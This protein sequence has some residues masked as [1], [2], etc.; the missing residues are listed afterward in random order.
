MILN[1]CSHRTMAMEVYWCIH[2]SNTR[3]D[4]ELLIRQHYCRSRRLIRSSFGNT[5]WSTF[6][7]LEMVQ[8]WKDLES[9]RDTSSLLLGIKKTYFRVWIITAEFK[10][11]WISW[12]SIQQRFHDN[13]YGKRS[14]VGNDMERYD[15]F[16]YKNYS[17]V[18]A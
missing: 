18:N 10:N 14:V 7:E 13:P 5:L 17:T 9:P 15:W 2:Y 6:L 1:F 4:Y 16:F 3:V 12:T 8:D 11:D